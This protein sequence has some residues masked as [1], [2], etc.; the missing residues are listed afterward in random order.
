MSPNKPFPLI[1]I[2][3]QVY[4]HSDGA[5]PNTAAD[6]IHHNRN[7]SFDR[8]I[9]RWNTA[10]K[11]INILENMS[12]DT[13]QIKVKLNEKTRMLKLNTKTRIQNPKCSEN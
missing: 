10:A 6:Y 5:L 3:S 8:W 9:N 2:L 1:N 13:T 12:I 11:R 7:N 4:Y